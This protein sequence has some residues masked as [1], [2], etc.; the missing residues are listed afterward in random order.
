MARKHDSA[1]SFVGFSAATDIVN[2]S[3]VRSELL[4]GAHLNEKAI[5][6]AA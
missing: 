2:C 4:H 1:I 3:I 6:V 5:A